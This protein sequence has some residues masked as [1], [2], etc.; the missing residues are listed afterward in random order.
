M[1][2]D[3]LKVY[4]AKT[5]ISVYD[6]HDYYLKIQ[7]DKVFDEMEAENESL[8]KAVSNWQDKYCNL[9]ETIDNLNCQLACAKADKDKELRAMKRAL[10]LARANYC[11]HF[12]VDWYLRRHPD[13]KRSRSIMENTLIIAEMACRKKAKEY[14]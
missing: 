5:A 2:R 12:R 9:Q 3:E 10:W 6:N 13:T 11:H 7:A 14:E 8:R 1:K 4:N